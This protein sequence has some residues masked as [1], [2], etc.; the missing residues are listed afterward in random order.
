MEQEQQ[1]R[2]TDYC[3]NWAEG[4]RGTASSVVCANILPISSVCVGRKSGPSP[5]PFSAFPS[6]VP[7]AQARR[8][9]Q[10]QACV[11]A[12]GLL[13]SLLRA[14]PASPF[15]PKAQAWAH[16]LFPVRLAVLAG[17]VSQGTD[18][19]AG[20]LIKTF[21][22]SALGGGRGWPEVSLVSCPF[23]PHH[24]YPTPAL[25]AHIPVTKDLTLSPLPD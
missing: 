4:K 22:H 17:S 11:G 6:E 14:R 1:L 19:T 21:P 8:C 20:A 25:P 24:S 12:I 9:W 2:N 13:C 7:E 16:L 10:G 3:L 5:Q 15:R 18:C 23:V